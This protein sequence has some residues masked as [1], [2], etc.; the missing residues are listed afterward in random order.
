M[1]APPTRSTD[2]LQA[3]AALVPLTVDQYHEMMRRGII[4]ESAQT[5]V[6]DGFLV[7]KDRSKRGEDPMVISSEHRW[8]VQKL[9]RIDSRV[10]V[11][12]MHVATQQPV[13]LSPIQEPEPDASI[14]NGP[15][16]DFRS[17]TPTARDVLCACEVADS[18]LKYDRTT[19]QRIYA[20]AG[21]PRYLIV[22]LVDRTVELYADP[23]TSAGRY[24]RVQTIK[25]GESFDIEL[26]AG[27]ALAVNADDVLP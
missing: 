15:L 25:P 1:T 11:W 20:T 18:S 10:Q 12:G 4:P 5:E 7:L 24:A 14:I 3:S 19:N 27:R 21:I 22:N 8:A 9:Q 17:R 13:A 6:I 23:D 2:W 26:E 16:D